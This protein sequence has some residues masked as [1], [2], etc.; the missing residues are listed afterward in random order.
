MAAM[1]TSCSLV[2]PISTHS[3]GSRKTVSCHA[4][5]VPACALRRSAKM[6]GNH[7]F[8]QLEGTFPTINNT[9][10]ASRLASFICNATADD[11]VARDDDVLP[12]SLLDS[13]IQAGEATAEAMKAV[14]FWLRSGV[15]HM[16]RA[17]TCVRIFC[18]T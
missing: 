3:R 15:V 18:K 10:K 6:V 1:M 8:G 9:N 13:V 17:H 14:G 16:K 7:P 5:I 2:A 11:A 4:H 12:D